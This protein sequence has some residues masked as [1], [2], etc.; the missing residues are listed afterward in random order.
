MSKGYSYACSKPK[1][2]N[3]NNLFTLP[4]SVQGPPW[5]LCFFFRFIPYLCRTQIG[6]NL[7]LS[8]WERIPQLAVVM[9]S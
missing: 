7:D 2:A 3:C 1:L 6:L 8:P 5:G 9:P 4:V